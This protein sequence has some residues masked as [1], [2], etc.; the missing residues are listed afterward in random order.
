MFSHKRKEMSL[1]LEE[2]LKNSVILRH[3]GCHL[4]GIVRDCRSHLGRIRGL[5]PRHYLCMCLSEHREKG[6]CLSFGRWFLCQLKNKTTKL[7]CSNIAVFCWPLGRS[8]DACLL[9]SLQLLGCSIYSS[10][11]FIFAY[12]LLSPFHSIFTSLAFV[13]I[14]K[15]MSFPKSP[16]SKWEKEWNG[17]S[18]EER[19]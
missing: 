5:A 10:T 3:S 8:G 6:G 7:K 1:L 19:H 13:L 9:L 15:A 2:S 14:A 16:A 17:A 4:L 11:P 18:D 12:W